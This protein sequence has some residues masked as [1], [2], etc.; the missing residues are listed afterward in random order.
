V[1]I[2][3]LKGHIVAALLCL[4]ALTAVFFINGFEGDKPAVPVQVEVR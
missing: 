2:L 4:I 3:T 1:R